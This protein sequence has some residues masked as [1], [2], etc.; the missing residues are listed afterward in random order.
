MD[1]TT[2]D[3]LI[4]STAGVAQTIA[5]FVGAAAFGVGA[6]LYA[7][8]RTA[9]LRTYLVFLTSIFLF[10]LSFWFR[11]IG[12]A[13]RALA[14]G[15]SATNGAWVMVRTLSGA[16]T[17]AEATGGIVL[18]LVLPRLTHGPFN[19]AV[20]AYRTGLAVVTAVAMA[21]LTLTI[22]AAPNRWAPVV[23]ISL[24]YATVAAS[25]GEMAVWVGRRR[26]D[27]SSPP[28]SGT[29]PG[30]GTAGAI[31]VFLLVSAAFLPL[32]VADVVI[33]SPGAG[34]WA[35]TSFGRALDDL[36]V[37]LYF[38]VLA[39]GSVA[40]AYRFLNEPPLLV[41]EQISDFARERYGLTNR[42]VEVVEYI[43]EGFTVA[44]AATAM[45][46]S[47]KTVENHLYAVYQKTGVT[48]RIQLYNLFENRRRL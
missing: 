4:I 33:S 18:V 47:P 6:F 27:P 23:L 3:A 46:I 7:T 40:F 44:D 14:T 39:A 10:V 1:R 8:H 21:A 35:R 5:V 11:E 19:R 28:P 31:R 16:S 12:M 22:V 29:D 17:L 26:A 43:V 32:F 2:G 13:I 37:P 42:E 38:I 24:M 45:R 25:I 20:P 30:D 9:V 15:A 41:D 36:S 34:T 48:N